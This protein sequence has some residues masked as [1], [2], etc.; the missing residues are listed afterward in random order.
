MINLISPNLKK[1]FSAGRINSILVR[2]IWIGVILFLLV[3]V[4]AGLT[5]AILDKTKT[6]AEEQI[7]EADARVTDYQM[8][9]AKATQFQSDLSTAKSILDQQTSY[10]SVLLKISK[11]MTPGTS[12][13]GIVLDNTTFG[14]PMDLQVLAKDESAAVRL[15]DSFQQSSLFSNV[16]FKS[17]S[18]GGSSAT[19]PI[20]VQFQV[21]INKE[22]AE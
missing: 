12:L 16:Q 8:T 7:R 22:S 11:L 3:V 20:T 9:Q 1:Q 19:Y 18:V 14:S 17:L 15:K 4:M 6:D 2:C 21:T 10:S 13:T 5:Y